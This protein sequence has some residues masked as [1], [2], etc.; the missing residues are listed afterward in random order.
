MPRAVHRI[1]YEYFRALLLSAREASGLT[2]AEVADLLGK[3]QSFV[4]KSER[5]ER[6]VDFTEF[7][8]FADAMQLDVGAF[9]A[10]YRERVR[11]LKA[12][13]TGRGRRK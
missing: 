7:L 8:E 11:S 5:G 3:H 6:R 9:L 13:P 4:S 2:Q 10:E 12:T 1:Q